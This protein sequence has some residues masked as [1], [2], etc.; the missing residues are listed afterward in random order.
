MSLSINSQPSPQKQPKQLGA[1]W[2]EVILKNNNNQTWLED[3]K[4]AETRALLS[5]LGA[6]TCPKGCKS[7]IVHLSHI[8]EARQVFRDPEKTDR[9]FVAPD[10]VHTEKREK[11]KGTFFCLECKH[12]WAMPNELTIVYNIEE[13]NDQQLPRCPYCH[14][15]ATVLSPLH[16]GS[17]YVC[18][19]CGHRWN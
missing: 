16:T 19:S 2:M 6:I 11:D 1:K 14:L 15:Q 8:I 3:T 10:P 17:K 12:E 13:K 9:C 7:Q 18:S 4:D 5:E